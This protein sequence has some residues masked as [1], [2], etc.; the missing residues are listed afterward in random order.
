[1]SLIILF[2]KYRILM[3]GYLKKWVNLRWQLRYFV[4]HGD[5]LVYCEKEGS[6]AKG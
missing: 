2:K 5:V 1:M 3:E 4:L 6:A